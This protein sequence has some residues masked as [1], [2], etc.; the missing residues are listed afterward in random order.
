LQKHQIVSIGIVFLTPD[1]Q[2]LIASHAFSKSL[3]SNLEQPTEILSTGDSV[4]FLE[5]K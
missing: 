4:E 2:L 3:L 1:K 5:G